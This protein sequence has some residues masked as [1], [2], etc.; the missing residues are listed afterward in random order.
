MPFDEKSKARLRHL[1]DSAAALMVECKVGCGDLI[2]YSSLADHVMDCV[3]EVPVHCV[4]KSCKHESKLW[5]EAIDHFKTA[6]SVSILLRDVSSLLTQP[7]FPHSFTVLWCDARRHR[8]FEHGPL[9]L[10]ANRSLNH[11]SNIQ[12]YCGFVL[13]LSSTPDR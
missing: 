13:G 3:G 4:Y 7:L 10:G 12:V 2:S 8:D 11:V 5:S 1:E 6:S 9:R